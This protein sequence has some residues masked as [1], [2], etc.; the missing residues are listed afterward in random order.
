[1]TELSTAAL[2]ARLNDVAATLKDKA[3]GL[4]DDALRAGTEL[5]GWTRGHILA[6][7]TGVSNAMARQVEFALRGET[8]ELYDGG[9]AGRNQAIEMAAG[10]GTDEHSR[11]LAAAVDRA[12]GAFGGLDDDG[13]RLPIA[14]R[15]GV[16]ADGARALWREMV[17]HLTDLQVGRGP[18]TWSREFCEHLVGFLSARVPADLRLKLQPIGLPPVTLGS[19][20]RSVSVNGMLTDIAAWL[21]GRTPTLGS[22]RAQAAADG[23]ELP[24]LLPWP[25]PRTAG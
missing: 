19:G 22:L 5:P 17:I 2:L 10:H 13:W 6:H 7:L 25:A 15:G 20:S 12:L 9:P 16:T 1:M 3:A 8:V 21:S 14:Y 18:E 4:G 11:D 23:V 24:A